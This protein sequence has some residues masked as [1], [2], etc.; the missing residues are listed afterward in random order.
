MHAHVH[1]NSGAG[2][3]QTLVNAARDQHEASIFVAF[4]E[5]STN[6]IANSDSFGWDL[7]G[8]ARKKLFFLDA[9][10]PHETVYGGEFDLLGLL[11]TVEA[12]RQELGAT[13]IVFDGIDVLLGFLNDP[14]AERREMYRL[15]E[16]LS[17]RKL[18]SIIT[19][20]LAEDGELSHHSYL[21]FLADCV[22][23][24]QHRLV[25]SMPS[26][27]CASRNAAA[28]PTLPAKYPSPSPRRAFGS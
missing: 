25:G 5:S 27:C 19:C 23:S 6:I 22:V 7:P 13:R 9:R 12:K 3:L 11:A 18:T 26:G 24:L 10:I 16:W 20:K 17:S 28:S 2:A 15:A 14:V 1:L 8:L 4:E 21:Q